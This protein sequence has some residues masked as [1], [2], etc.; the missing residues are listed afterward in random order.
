MLDLAVACAGRTPKYTVPDQGGQS[1][2]E[3]SDWCDQCGVTA[4]GI[5]RVAHVRRHE[6]ARAVLARLGAETAGN[7]RFWNVGPKEKKA[8]TVPLLAQD[9][10]TEIPK[11]RTRPL[12][13]R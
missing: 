2:E 5:L 7:D 11:S 6:S 3:Y 8:E 10:W 4:H 12:D 1:G 9:F 13:S